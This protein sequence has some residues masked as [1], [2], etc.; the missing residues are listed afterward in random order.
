MKKLITI[1]D[2]TS[3]FIQPCHEEEKLKRWHNSQK[4]QLKQAVQEQQSIKTDN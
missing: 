1:I 3:R 4:T 2:L